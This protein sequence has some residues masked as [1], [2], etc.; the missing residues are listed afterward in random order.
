MP[1]SASSDTGIALGQ[2]GSGSDRSRNLA[3]WT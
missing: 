3:T 2:D 1:P